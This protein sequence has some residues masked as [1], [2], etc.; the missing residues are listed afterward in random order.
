MVLLYSWAP[1]GSVSPL[2]GLNTTFTG[3]TLG[4]TTVVLTITDSLT[5]CTNTVSTPITVNDV[6]GT[7]TCEGDTICGQGN[8]TLT[9]TGAGSGQLFWTENIGG[10]ILGLGN[11][12]TKAVTASGSDFVREF[13]ANLD[14][15]NIGY[16]PITNPSAA[17][18]YF[19]TT[20]QGMWFSVTN[21]EGVI[22]KSVDVIPNGPVGS[23]LT[24]AVIDS[25]GNTIGTVSTVTTV[26]NTSTA[27]PLTIRLLYWHLCSLQRCSL[28]YP[29]GF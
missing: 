16:D 20:A 10:N 11:S 5:G 29:S 8:V 28:C 17:V 22:L 26:T 25:L 23:P 4:T 9:A 24:I 18:G 1:S 13:P 27:S 21:T 3:S 2:T 15:T 14:T 12:L 7:P 19:P 6:P